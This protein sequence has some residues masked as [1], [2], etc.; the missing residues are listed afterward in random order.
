M[1]KSL[2]ALALASVIGFAGAAFAAGPAFEQVD[3]DK[4]G[5]ISKAE[6]AVV[7][8]LDFAKADVDKD[9]MLDRSEY[10]AAVS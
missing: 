3:R 7:K 4:D 2:C 9:G 1:K 5:K 8:T 6:A 10:E